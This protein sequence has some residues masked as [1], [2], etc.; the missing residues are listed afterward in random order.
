M[1][2][3]VKYLNRLN[4]KLY[5]YLIRQQRGDYYNGYCLGNIDKG[6]YYPNISVV[7]SVVHVNH[8]KNCS[9]R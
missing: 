2:K 3:F 1:K 6:K 5:F 8:V 4:Y 9:R 7:T